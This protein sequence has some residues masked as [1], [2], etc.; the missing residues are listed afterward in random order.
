[1]ADIENETQHVLRH[2]WHPVVRARDLVDKPVAVKLLGEPLVLWRTGEGV[3]VFYDLCIHRGTPLSLGWVED[4]A[5]VCAYHGWRYDRKGLCTRIPSIPPDR[6]IPSKARARVYQAQERYGFIW[7]CLDEPRAPLPEFPP[8]YED[9]AFEWE[10]FSTEGVWQANA[11][12]I[13]ENL[14]DYSHFPWVH[15][16]TLGDRD[17]PE[18]E[19]ISIH[20]IEGGFR[21]VIDQP[22][23]TLR[24]D[25]A[26]R[27]L[28]TLILPYT[29]FIQRWQ[30]GGTERLT[31]I[32]LCCPISSKET[33]YFRRMGKNFRGFRTNEELNARH[34]LTF[35][36]DRVIV[37]AQRPEELPL[38]LSEELHLRGP[39]APAVE[40]RKQLR[41]LGL[42][43][44]E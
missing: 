2:Y 21:Y 6:P 25:A 37:E 40:Y 44:S 15:P 23:N 28:Y 12:R 34:R 4:D 9:P 41:R 26:A 20:T 16:D 17:N 29:L 32:F 5:I 13:I 7:V 8:E 1:M 43:W 39:D 33:K 22:V 27:Q 38:D 31:N 42:E 3:A 11:A 14:A 30:P 19:D 24:A 36:Q 18:C 35:A 10:P